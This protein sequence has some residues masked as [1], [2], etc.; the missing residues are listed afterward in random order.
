MSIIPSQNTN[1]QNKEIKNNETQKTTQK[2]GNYEI[3]KIIG[4]GT[5]GKVKLAK[6]IPTGELV[7]IKIL[8][9]SKI[10]DNDDLACVTRE[11]KFLKGLHHINLISLYEIIETARNYYIIMEYAENELF[12]YI[13]SN[14]YLS[15]EISSFFYIQILSTTE[16]IYSNKIVHWDLKPENIL[17]T[18]NNNLI[19][20]IDFGLSNKYIMKMCIKNCL[21]LTLL[22]SRR[23]MIDTS[24]SIE[25]NSNMS[26]IHNMKLSFIPN[27]ILI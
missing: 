23:N 22:C 24:L 9:K 17:L 12:S 4:E 18:C 19:N 27:K 8:E 7:A 13:V 10:E 14:N 21:W 1:N 20:I 3:I 26:K 2:I 15:E 16:S 5:F 25:L 6:N 11:I